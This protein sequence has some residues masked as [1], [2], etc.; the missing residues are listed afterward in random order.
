MARAGSGLWPGRIQE[1]S[2]SVSWVSWFFHQSFLLGKSATRQLPWSA[3]LYLY[4]M[5][6]PPF[7]PFRHVWHGNKHME[8]RNLCF[9]L[10]FLSVPTWAGLNKHIVTY[11]FVHDHARLK[12]W[13]PVIFLVKPWGMWVDSPIGA[14]S[15][16]GNALWL[17]SKRAMWMSSLRRLARNGKKSCLTLYAYCSQQIHSVGWN[18]LEHRSDAQNWGLLSFL[19]SVRWIGICFSFDFTSGT[20]GVARPYIKAV[21]VCS[22]IRKS[23][24]KHSQELHHNDRFLEE[25]KKTSWQILLFGMI[26]ETNIMQ[27]L[28]GNGIPVPDDVATA[29]LRRASKIFPNLFGS[30]DD[31]NFADCISRWPEYIWLL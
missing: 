24:M 15:S 12:T 31:L 28:Q 10:F 30:F 13:F 16:A 6:T 1:A 25:A 11:L 22:Q 19:E 26:S 18:M 29:K 17:S 7:G 9:M 27:L 8:K 5:K 3:G 4:V 23:M 2:S 14:T 20:F 21:P